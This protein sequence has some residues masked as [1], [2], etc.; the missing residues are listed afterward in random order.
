MIKSALKNEKN[1]SNYP[2]RQADR[3]QPTGRCLIYLLIRIPANKNPTT[4]IV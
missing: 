1:A 3:V 2:I 4:T